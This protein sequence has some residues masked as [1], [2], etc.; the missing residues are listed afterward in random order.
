MLNQKTKQSW[1]VV[2]SV[3]AL[4][5]E[6]LKTVASLVAAKN[7]SIEVKNEIN[8]ALIGGI[9]VTAFGKTVDLSLLNK[10]NQLRDQLAA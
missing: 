4:T 8:P 3:V 7:T 2:E 9:R 10:L 5:P 6:E 1:I